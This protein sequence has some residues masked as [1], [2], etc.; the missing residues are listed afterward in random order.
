MRVLAVLMVLLML[1]VSLSGCGGK[2]STPTPTATTETT[3]TAPPPTTTTPP[4]T[5]TTTPPPPTTTTTPPP[6]TT[7]TPTSTTP[8]PPAPTVTFS[9]NENADRLDVVAPTANTADWNR[10]AIKI[11]T[12]SGQG[13][14]NMGNST[15]PLGTAGFQNEE[16]AKGGADND[17]G[18]AAFAE[19]T[20]E[21]D[22]MVVGDFLD[23]C[24][25]GVS[26]PAPNV[27][28]QVRD[29]PTQKVIGNYTFTTVAV[30]PALTF[31]LNDA[32]DKLIVDTVGPDGDWN[33]L[34]VRLSGPAGTGTIHLGNPPRPLFNEAPQAG[35]AS[36]DV[37]EAQEIEVA[38]AYAKITKDDYL[39]FC[40]TG[41]VAGAN[42]KIY[43]GPDVIYQD[44][45]ANFADLAA[46]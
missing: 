10:L 46:C 41:T 27:E 28:F 11:K 43:D 31:K 44:P 16:S 29:T 36:N 24:V 37:T 45:L 3:T 2:K 13:T 30:C 17:I 18:T 32:D 23:I 35:D 5:T 26:L 20:S 42:I 9:V 19:I 21:L 14:L 12:I 38:D 39:R 25:S 4:P 7:T 1:T 33:R 6:T 15:T 8:P 40:R 22:L 34:T